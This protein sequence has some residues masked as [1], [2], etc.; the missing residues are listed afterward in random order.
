M[1]LKGRVTNIHGDNNTGSVTYA[2]LAPAGYTARID[3]TNATSTV[4][5]NEN[6]QPTSVQDASGNILPISLQ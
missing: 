3:A 1:T 6:G 2:Y 5:Y 4:Q